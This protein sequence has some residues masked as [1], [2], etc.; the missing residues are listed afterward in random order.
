M[1]KP[2][3]QQFRDDAT[4]QLVSASS[5]R[6]NL[7]KD[8]LSVMEP[9]YTFNESQWYEIGQIIK[10]QLGKWNSEQKSRAGKAMDQFAKL[11]M[12]I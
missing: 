12:T 7:K 1:K 3:W 2:A 6:T 8:A 5:Y 4:E 10:A 11:I 9:G